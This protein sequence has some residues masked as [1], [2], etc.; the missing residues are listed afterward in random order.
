MP[1]RRQRRRGSPADLSL[2]QWPKCFGCFSERDLQCVAPPE[3]PGMARSCGVVAPCRA[4]TG[5]RIVYDHELLISAEEMPTAIRIGIEIVRR[6]K[7]VKVAHE[8][9]AAW[10][11]AF[12]T[13][14]ESAIGC[15]FLSYEAVEPEPESWYTMPI[16]SVITDVARSV[17]FWARVNDN[18]ADDVLLARVIIG[19]DAVADVEI[20]SGVEYLV[21]QFAE[22]A[23]IASRFSI[24]ELPQPRGSFA[25]VAHGVR[26]ADLFRLGVLVGRLAERD[27]IFKLGVRAGRPYLRVRQ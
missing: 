18:E 10:T 6:G 26:P 20:C 19:R 16:R 23:N 2:D 27:Q 4:L 1:L 17:G 21:D 5:K 22:A 15:D 7:S 12:R 11:K 8:R 13:G 14:L 25:F 24:G 9:V 3:T